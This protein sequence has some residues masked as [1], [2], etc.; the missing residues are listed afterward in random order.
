M[1]GNTVNGYIE[2]VL[3][4]V[5]AKNPGEDEFLQAVCEVYGTLGPVIER[6]P[7]YQTAKILEQM[8]EPE[9]VIMF[10][11]PWVDDAGESQLNRG[12]RVQMNSAIGPLQGRAALPPDRLPRAA[13]VPRLRAGVQER[14]HHAADGRRQGRVG[15]RPEGQ[16]RRRGPAVLPV[17]HDRAVPAHRPVHRRPSRGHR[18]RQ[19]GDRLPVRPVQADHRRVHRCPHRQGPQLGRLADPARGD[20]LRR[21][22]LRARRCSPPAATPWPA[23]PA[24]SPAAGTSPSTRSRRCSTSAPSRSR[25]RTPTASSTTGTASTGRSWPGCWT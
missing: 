14:A 19:A 4:Q 21:G 1:T 13:E 15:F 20:R 3:N 25:S 9:R 5:Q 22:V 2:S 24:S 8:A 11:V 16:E 17:V 10:R 23:R 12:F 18:R 6:H 7:E